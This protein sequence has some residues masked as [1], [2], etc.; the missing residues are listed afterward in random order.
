[1]ARVDAVPT[2]TQP[3]WRERAVVPQPERGPLAGRGAGAALP[4]RRVRAH[5]REGHDRLHDPRGRR[6]VEAVAARLLRVLRRQGRA[7]AR[8]VRGD[9]ARSGRRHPRRRRRASPIRS[10]ACAPSRSAARVVRPRRVAAQARHATTA[11]PISEFSMH[12]AVNHAERVRAALAPL[13]HLLARARRRRR[14]RGRDPRRRHAPRR[15]ARAAD[16]DVQLV[17]QP[18]RRRTRS[19]RLTAEETWQFC[20]HGLRG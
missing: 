18:A 5:R 10:R 7:R 6:T 14:G 13:S 15:R 17:R 3:A 11:A 20:L 8:A 19:S 16:G 1:M 9:R 12:L 4:R 2:R